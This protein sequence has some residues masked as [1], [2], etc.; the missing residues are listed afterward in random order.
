[1]RDDKTDLERSCSQRD[2]KMSAGSGA[3]LCLL[4]ISSSAAIDMGACHK[5][6][7]YMRFGCA[8]GDRNATMSAL[9]HGES[10]ISCVSTMRPGPAAS[11]RR[12][13]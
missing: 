12:P 3:G 5:S 2:E 13:P 11:S 1:M 8:A 4:T 10:E 7:S 6:G 9:P